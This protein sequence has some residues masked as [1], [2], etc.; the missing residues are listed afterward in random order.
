MPKKT[1][2]RKKIDIEKIE[3]HE[4]LQV[5]FSKR[6][7]GVFTKANEIGTRC[8][9][10]TAVVVYSP[11]GKAY[12][13]GHPNVETVLDRYLNNAPA[14]DDDAPT[15]L[16]AYRNATIQELNQQYNDLR[17]Q[18][19]AEVIRG[20]M[21]KANKEVA[22]FQAWLNRPLESFSLRDLAIMQK[23]MQHLKSNVN[24]KL[25]ELAGSSS[26]FV[27]SNLGESVDDPSIPDIQ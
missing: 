2:G 20:K 7:L 27:V 6:R 26:S 23:A 3:N 8:G 17:D 24:E 5:A 22:A 10:Q 12:S 9:A 1:A 14:P 19:E 25:K 13:Y 15:A 4:R 11:A 18:L 16:E 21:L